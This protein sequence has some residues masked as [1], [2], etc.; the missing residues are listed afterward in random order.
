MMYSLR[1]LAVAATLAASAVPAWSA[2]T[3]ISGTL[4]TCFGLTPDAGGTV[5]PDGN[6]ATA[7]NS[8]LTA[9][10]N[11]GTLNFANYPLPQGDVWATPGLN[12][13]F[14]GSTVTADFVDAEAQ[15]V[16]PDTLTQTV[17]GQTVSLRDL[18]RFSTSPVG[19]DANRMVLES[20]GSFTMKFSA[21]IQAFGF[22]GSDIGDFGGGLTLELFK[23][24]D[25]VNPSQTFVVVP[26]STP[27][28][29]ANDQGGSLLFFG[30]IDTAVGYKKIRFVHQNFVNGDFTDVDGFG[31]DDML[32]ASV[33]DV[34]NPTPE[35]ASLALLGAALAAAG[36]SRRR[37]RRTS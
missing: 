3:S 23:D 33:N 2:C 35:P 18:G 10:V 20:A 31:Y 12:N 11:H 17:N 4:S 14:S 22:F 34:P 5:D 19:D 9:T 7:R 30:F 29:G 13:A 37:V 8:F 16:I 27:A 28:T 36:L 32:I 21:A 25:G 26:G 15:F 1:I 6:A 24:E